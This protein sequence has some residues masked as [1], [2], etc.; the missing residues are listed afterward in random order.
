MQ[1]GW[2][3]QPPL[4]NDMRRQKV[5]S[6]TQN[7]DL[8]LRIL[9]QRFI[10]MLLDGGFEQL[11]LSRADRESHEMRFSFPFGYM[12]RIK[13]RNFELLEVQLD[14]HGRTKFVVNVGIVPPEG[15]DVPWKHFDQ[16]EARVSALSESYRLYSCRWCMKWFSVP[17]LT[18]PFDLESRT[19]NAVD[20]AIELYPEIEAWFAARTVGPHM[21]RIGYPSVGQRSEPR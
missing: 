2:E 11:P 9:E 16:T 1:P 3:S 21:R 7:R 19:R 18:L 6:M 20:R 10:R 17:W 13:G 8:L 14:K 4:E 12:R 5:Q 15:A